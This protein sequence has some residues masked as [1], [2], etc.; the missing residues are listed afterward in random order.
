MTV[1]IGMTGTD[2][3]FIAADTRTH[4]VQAN[5]AKP[6]A[7]KK[8]MVWRNKAVWG[9]GGHSTANAKIS[10]S[11]PGGG[12]P[13]QLNEA[14]KAASE[15]VVA[16]HAEQVRLEGI[17]DPSVFS[18]VVS[19]TTGFGPQLF[20]NS[21][22][23]QQF[24]AYGPGQFVCL[25]SE[26]EVT[27]AYADSRLAAHA[28]K[29]KFLPARWALDVMGWAA[30]RDPLRVAFPVDMYLIRRNRHPEYRRV[31]SEHDTSPSWVISVPNG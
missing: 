15:L 22:K 16:S 10:T 4:F 11:L 19:C 2:A 29:G 7:T 3:A 26:T 6:G 28:S 1:L 18:I 9:T 12:S 17:T 20:A 5:V 21:T 8:L 13:R 23:L 24:R 14:I 30:G 25:A 31:G 27:Q